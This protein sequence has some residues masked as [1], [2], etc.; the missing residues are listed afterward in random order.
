MIDSVHRF[1]TQARQ[2][3]P[4]SSS[5]SSSFLPSSLLH[6]SN[7]QTWPD[8]RFFFFGRW[9]EGSVGGQHKQAN[10]TQTLAYNIDS[11]TQPKF[12]RFRSKRKRRGR[13]EPGL[14]G[15][16]ASSRSRLQARRP[17]RPLRVHLGAQQAAPPPALQG[18]LAAALPDPPPGWG[19]QAAGAAALVPAGRRRWHGGP[20][21]R[22]R[23]PGGACWS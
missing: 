17:G 20:P 11:Y 14:A 13:W 22:R 12:N 19:V 18:L 10:T 7:F 3:A 9:G 4:R 2:A 5:S 23:A 21:P 16:P 6:L 15:S 1:D 8:R